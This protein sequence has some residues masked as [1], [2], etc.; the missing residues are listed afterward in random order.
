LLHERYLS[1]YL[2]KFNPVQLRWD[3]KKKP[4]PSYAIYNFGES[5]GLSFDRV[6]IY[7]TKEMKNWIKNNSVK[8]AEITRAKIYVAITR[9]R[10]SVAIVVDDDMDEN[11][12]DSDCCFYNPNTEKGDA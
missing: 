1:N 11:I 8:L 10:K 6:I 9:A 3:S 12:T 2:S 5:K 7:P 4:D